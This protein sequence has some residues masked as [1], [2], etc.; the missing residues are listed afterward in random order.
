MDPNRTLRQE[1][2]QVRAEIAALEGELRGREAAL[3]R[4]QSQLEVLRR[5]GQREQAASLVR[6]IERVAADRGAL[7]ERL[8]AGQKRAEGLFERFLQTPDPS[9][10][11]GLLETGQAIALL[12]VRLET[13]FRTGQQ[14][15]DL[16]VRIYPD[17]VHVEVHEPELTEE[18]VLAG[19]AFWQATLAADDAPEGGDHSARLSAWAQLAGQ[20]GPERAAWIAR[21][22]APAVTENG[23]P[24]FPEPPRHKEAWTR[25]PRARALPDRWVI[26]G[27]RGGKRIFAVWGRPVPDPLPVGLSPEADIPIPAEGE[28]ALDPS[29]RWMFDFD[30]AERVGMGVR[31]PLGDGPVQPIEVLLA[32]GVKASADDQDSAQQLA[33]L[34]DG[35]HYSAGMSF[36]RQGSPTNNTGDGR[37]AFNQ[38]DA[39]F[40]RSFA[41]ERGEPLFA[42]G[43]GSN[44]DVSAA[45]LGLDPALFSHLADAGL[46]EQKEAGCMNA[47][48]WHSTWGYFLDQAMAPVF[49]RNQ[50]AAFRNHF[51]NHVRG[52]GPLPILRVGN[53]PYGLLPVTTLDGIGQNQ[54]AAALTAAV[55]F[56]K[57]LRDEF[58]KPGIDGVPH[59]DAG[60]DPDDTLLGILGM[61]ATS[62]EIAGR[63]VFGGHFFRNWWNWHGFAGFAKYNEQ[64]Q[65]M[66]REA[67]E[68]L[69]VPWSP[70]ALEFSFLPAAFELTGPRV[71]SGPLSETQLLEPNYITW[72]RTVNP[73]RIRDEQIEGGAP[74]SLLYLLLRHAA[75]MA[76][77]VAAFQIMARFQLLDSATQ[78]EPELLHFNAEEPTLTVLNVLDRRV[79]ELTENAPLADYL[80]DR[81]A[82]DEPE[83]QDYTEFWQA[84]EC[85]EGLSTSALDR[86][87]SETLDLCSHRLDAWITSFAA[88]SLRNLRQEHR[89]TGIH[90]GG[91]GWVENLA[92]AEAR[93]SEGYLQ[94]PSLQQ[95]MTGAVLRS[96]YLTHAGTDGETALAVDL[97]SARARLALSILDAVRQGQP[98]GAVLGYRF[99]R[100]LH[101]D[102][103]T[104]ELDR[105]ILPIRELAPLVARKKEQTDEP[106]ESIAAH[107]VVDGMVLNRRWKEDDIPWGEQ[108]LPALGSQDEAAISIELKRLD[109]VIDAVSDAVT[110]ESVFQAI[111]GNPTHSGAV[112]DAIARGEA[113]PPE[114][115]VV[116]TARS[117][118]GLTHRL[119]LAFSGDA[120]VPAD[121]PVDVRQERAQA[122]PHLNAWLGSMLGSPDRVRCQVEYLDPTDNSVL[123]SAPLHLGQLNLSPLDVLQ[124]ANLDEAEGSELERRLAFRASN[125]L[126]PSVPEDAVL[127][128]VFTRDPNWGAEIVDFLAFAEVVRSLRE[129]VSRA[130]SLAPA[131]VILPGKLPGQAFDS[132]ELQARAD[133][134][135]GGYGD[136]LTDLQGLIA[137]SGAASPADLRDRLIR[138]AHFGVQGA[139][140]LSLHGA[141][142]PARQSLLTQAASVEREMRGQMERESALEAEFDRATATPAEQREHDLARL[143]LVF[144]PDFPVLPRFTPDV[145][146]EL[147]QAFA[148][149]Q[150]VQGGDPQQVVQWL[151]RMTR[152]RP[153]ATAFGDAFMYADAL[154]GTD[155]LTL[156]VGQLPFQADD[157]WIG[158]PTD[159]GK[160]PEANRL[161]LVAQ[162]AEGFDPSGPVAGMLVDEWIE[163]L[164]S[165]SETTGLTFHFDQPD[166]RAP[167]A[168]LLALPPDLGRPWDLATLEKILLET[169]EL[170][171]LRAVDTAALAQLGQFLPALFFASN[172]RGETVSTDFTRNRAPDPGEEVG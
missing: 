140:P 38:P 64:K 68:E 118:I 15:T 110:A 13:H 23:E 6:Q 90:L 69:G 130:R 89:P 66:A 115:E 59:V 16:L 144:G 22:L 139:F 129:L 117:G 84:L 54:Y 11:F 123:D 122:E 142:D 81:H 159:E 127:H 85:L 83:T 14:G 120:S 133:N 77:G 103:P 141:D 21:A 30:E 58:W 4:L 119:L 37:S 10:L 25:A 135:V 114:L 170:A 63:P 73:R 56:V 154:S 61:E 50:I 26:L 65:A 107:N 113:P 53:Q 146:G 99:E 92:S 17:D 9:D 111:R 51:V 79:P 166:A 93:R 128:L 31:V 42:P 116:R 167:N 157:R 143:A 18:E 43:D 27:Y 48:L 7:S 33:A 121:W 36:V 151:Q 39:T 136:L 156:Q 172:V 95:A 153:G 86:L 132:T 91:F 32:L 161:S 2:N 165:A 109:D 82:L 57:A 138:A 80:H 112:L 169:L 137:L 125:P 20:F 44:G 150:Q 34:L 28:P 76:Y 97:S 70:R 104:R 49:N 5:S 60:Q 52:R 98:L 149:S 163:I 78:P 88:Q 29:V 148:A 155:R 160:L 71:Q 105:Y 87:L 106:L 147:A 19:R 62:L 108:D 168:I 45:A 12:P 94:A 55:G 100:G 102:H 41:I 72:L 67:L 3:T 35:H 24:N 158:L 96:G 152:V 74:N 47:A 8:A 131:D 124:I 164:P 126:P 75:L 162:L 134:A 101:E 171:K 40:E 145:P 1:L 46:Q